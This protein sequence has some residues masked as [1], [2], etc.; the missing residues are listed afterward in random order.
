MKKVKQKKYYSLVLTSII[1]FLIFIFNINQVQAEQV[2]IDWKIPAEDTANIN[3][4]VLMRSK[5]NAD[6]ISRGAI[7]TNDTNHGYISNQDGTISYFA[8]DYPTSPGNYKYKIYINLSDGETIIADE[9]VMPPIEV[10]IICD[11]ENCSK[12]FINQGSLSDLPLRRNSQEQKETRTNLET[13]NERKS[14]DSSEA[15]FII[16]NFSVTLL[17][18]GH[19]KLTWQRL[20]QTEKS[21][22]DYLE[23][24]RTDPDGTPWIKEIKKTWYYYTDNSNPAPGEYNYIINV[25]LRS[26]NGGIVSAGPV[27]I[28]IPD[29]SIK[30][31]NFI[32]EKTLKRKTIDS[33]ITINNFIVEIVKTVASIPIKIS[34]FIIEKVSPDVANVPTS[35][36]PFTCVNID[37]TNFCGEKSDIDDNCDG[38]ISCVGNLICNNDCGPYLDVS[39]CVEGICEECSM[40]CSSPD[41]G[42][43]VG[44]AQCLFDSA[45]DNNICV[46]NENAPKI[47]IFNVYQISGVDNRIV[48]SWNVDSD[49]ENKIGHFELWRRLSDEIWNKIGSDIDVTKKGIIDILSDYGNYEYGLHIVSI[50]GLVY[51]TETTSGL[52]PISVQ[53]ISENNSKSK[54]LKDTADNIDLDVGW[55]HR[56]PEIDYVWGSSNPIVEGW[57]EIDQEVI[58]QANVRNWSNTEITGVKY[59]WYF[60]DIEV[61][62]GIVDIP[63]DSYV[64]VEYDWV[65]TFNRHRLKFVI[66]SD[67][68]ITEEEEGNNELEIFTDAITVGFYVEQSLYDYFHQYQRELAGVHSNSWEDWAQRQV[69]LWNEMFADA[70]YPETPDGV[71][72]RIRLDKITIVADKELPLAGGGIP[73]NLPNRDDRTIDLQWGFSSE[74]LDPGN[75]WMYSDHTTVADT[76]FFY[77]EGSL[78]HELGHARYL[79]DV[80]GFNIEEDGSGS[81]VAIEESG[82]LIVD[83]DYMPFIG[84]GLYSPVGYQGLMSGSY[85][86]IGRYSATALNLIAGH[87]AIKG[88]YNSPNNIGV[89]KNDLPIENKLIIRD[90]AGNALIGADVKIY[91]AEGINNVWYGKYYDDIPDLELITDTNGQVLLGINPFDDDLTIEHTYGIA[92]GVIIIRIEKDGNIEYKFLSSLHF[93]MEYWRGNTEVGEYTIQTSIE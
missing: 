50:D 78:L 90:S 93:N 30:I 68:A 83:T 31:N 35:C 89:Y 52:S 63:A 85:T 61:D 84:W 33:I 53:K 29:R 58:W 64:T 25:R 46:V 1:F 17:D 92:N 37:L 66:D 27:S 43:D 24:V 72:D 79:I 2:K 38:T 14:S 16:K 34:N 48:I 8:Y 86:F 40:T 26:E 65:W 41:V 76:N 56:S 88:N 47:S 55:I 18:N 54:T 6:W 70:I 12:D 13:S 20:N 91:Q 87:R 45:T 62:S 9:A 28:T 67:S 69:R 21:L 36:T 71:L 51:G 49:E 74:A 11:G 59:K 15:N 7:V 73:S 42:C 3:N 23:I 44:A 81:S 80:Y 4:F 82:N 57:P 39:N 75:E 60:D 5:D 19:P 10:N 22:V 77:Y 32:I